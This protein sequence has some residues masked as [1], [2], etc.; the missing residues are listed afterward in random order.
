MT[1][2]RN[3]SVSL[4]MSSLTFGLIPYILGPNA[5]LARLR[6]EA[7][8]LRRA[9]TAISSFRIGL[10]QLQVSLKA[11]SRQSRRGR[12]DGGVIGDIKARFVEELEEKLSN[13]PT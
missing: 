10:Q 12:I 1:S 6:N 4:Q 8:H 13:V 7:A 3:R 11:L 9:Y 2:Q 5:Y